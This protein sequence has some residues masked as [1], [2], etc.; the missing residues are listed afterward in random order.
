M[1]RMSSAL[2]KVGRMQ[3]S[4]LGHLSQRCNS[5]DD[6]HGPQKKCLLTEL[7]QST[8]SCFKNYFYKKR[9]FIEPV[10]VN[11]KVAI[12]IFIGDY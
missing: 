3:E 2:E 12:G 11:N 9:R 1:G 6:R 5:Q 7:G 8:S 10:L 4:N